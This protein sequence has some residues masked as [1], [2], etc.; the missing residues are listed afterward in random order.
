MNS[1]KGRSTSLA[2]SAEIQSWILRSLIP[3]IIMVTC[4]LA[5]TDFDMKKS[6]TAFSKSIITVREMSPAVKT[7]ALAL[8]GSTVTSADIVE[9]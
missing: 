7:G 6:N 9:R 8:V 5:G 1:E 4:F 2:H 3:G